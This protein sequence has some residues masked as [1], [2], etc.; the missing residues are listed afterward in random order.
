MSKFTD[1]IDERK[2]R[3]KE[4]ELIN[5]IDSCASKY[6][7][8]VFNKSIFIY[9][10]FDFN[11]IKDVAKKHFNASVTV[12]KVIQSNSHL[13]CWQSFIIILEPL[14]QLEFPLLETNLSEIQ[15]FVEKKADLF[16]E[17]FKFISRN[18]VINVF[19]DRYLVNYENIMKKWITKPFTE[20]EQFL[21]S[22]SSLSYSLLRED[23]WQFELPDYSKSKSLLVNVYFVSWIFLC[24]ANNGEF[25]SNQ[26]GS[27]KSLSKEIMNLYTKMSSTNK[28]LVEALADIFKEYL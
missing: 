12:S 2:R 27:L 9:P 20:K 19:N 6:P 15:F 8:N 3:K 13:K 4:E 1:F 10:E 28:H 25:T 23:C 21:I 24:E 18:Y 7:Y 16:S 17:S 11:M 22:F 14:K 5:I 26:I